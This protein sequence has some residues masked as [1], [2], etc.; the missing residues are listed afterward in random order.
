MQGGQG[1]KLEFKTYKIN[2][3]SFFWK[4]ICKSVKNPRRDRR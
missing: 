1:M 2:E 4:T 3:D